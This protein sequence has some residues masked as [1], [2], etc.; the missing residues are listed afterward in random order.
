MGFKDK[1][2]GFTA[3]AKAKVEDQAIKA[4]KMVGEKMGNTVTKAKEKLGEKKDDD[5]L[6]IIKYENSVNHVSDIPKSKIAGEKS[7]K[8]YITF[9]FPIGSAIDSSIL[10]PGF[11][12]GKVIIQ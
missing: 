2:A 11:S 12:Y 10:T 9:F 3:K 5:A 6:N 1:I 8:S 4:K 7:L